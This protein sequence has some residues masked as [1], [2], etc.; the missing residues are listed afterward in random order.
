MS[1]KTLTL[2]MGF[3][4][5]LILVVGGIFIA[6]AVGGGGDDNGTPSSPGDQPGRTS[7]PGSGNSSASA[8]CK[9]NSLILVG[10]EPNSVFDPIQV[11][12]QATS[13]YMVEI[14]G[15]L[16]TLDTKL[17]I[18]PDLAEKWDISP[19][20]KVY[21]FKLKN[22][23]VFHNSTR[24]TARDVKYSIER[25]ADPANASPTAKAYL[26]RI[27]GLTEKLD[28]KAKEV[29]GVK[30]IDD[31]NIE[32]TLTEPEDFFLAEL[33]YPVAYVVDQKQIE[34]DPRNWTRKPNGTGPFKVAEYKPQ[35]VIRLVRNDRYHLGAPKLDELVFELAG[36]S[37]STRYDNNELHVGNVT[38]QILEEIAGGSAPSSKDYR[39]V[40]ELAVSYFTLNTKQAPFDDPKVRQAFA[41]AIDRDNI[42]KVLLYDAYKV[43]DGI[44][45]P[46]MPGYSESVSSY[47]YDPAKAKQLL[48]ESRY[49][50]NMPRII[51]TYSGGGGSSPD[52]LVAITTGWQEV[53]GVKVELQAVETA[54]FLRELRR[55]TFQMA[56]EGW[57]ADYP[58]PENFLGKLFAS[59][60]PLNYT[61]YK[62]DEVDALLKQARRET[63]RETRLGLYHEAEQKILDEASVLPIFWPVNH[64]LVKPCVINYPNVA[65]TVEKYRLVEIDPNAK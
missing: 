25:A 13:E 46:D 23:I 12:D 15:G 11:G 9:G 3:V 54:A 44:L 5:F 47:K 41:S 2:L 19:D 48:S 18:I 8:I 37:V 26:G 17:E 43:A 58:D 1:N 36:G 57:A 42:N 50:S 55:G 22:N 62:N 31:L 6:V 61:K 20:G 10:S 51:M 64:V 38:Q 65:M 30:V 59:D 40:N 34:N 24:V 16:V 21:R 53:L 56:S 39:A 14:F 27:Q 60:S 29:S 52:V 33:T 28:G 4:A 35:E 32:I 45:P 63:N 7:T 49:A